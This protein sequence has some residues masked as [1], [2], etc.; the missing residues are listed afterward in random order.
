MESEIE[1]RAEEKAKLQV[2]SQTNAIEKLE[3]ELAK[4]RNDKNYILEMIKRFLPEKLL[5]RFEQ[6]SGILFHNQERGRSR[7]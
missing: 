3:E 2:N 5:E 1:R 7:G 4:E 6:F